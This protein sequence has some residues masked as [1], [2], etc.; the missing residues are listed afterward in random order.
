MLQL[1]HLSK[2]FLSL[3]LYLYKPISKYTTVLNADKALQTILKETK[4]LSSEKAKLRNALGRTLAEDIVAAENIPPFDNSAMDGFAVHS[5]DVKKASQ[6]IPITLSVAGE[7]SAGNVFD[8]KLNQGEAV[9]IMTGAKL[10]DGADC[11]V[12]IELVKIGDEQKVE[13][14]APS[15]AGAHIRRAGEDFKKKEVALSKGELISPAQ[16]GVLA[17]FGYSKVRVVCKPKVN[18]LAT[19][20]ELVEVADKLSEGQIRNSSSYALAGFVEQA[21]GEATLLGI[22]RDKRKR[23]RKAI[24]AGLDCDVL[25]ITGGVS[26]GKYD[27]VKDILADLG[28]GIKFWK[29]NIKPG[30]PLVFG[31]FKKTLVFGLPGNP[32]STSVTY[33]QFV[34][35]AIHKMLGRFSPGLLRLSAILD[36]PITKNDGKRHF[37][38]GIATTKGGT[39]HV[40]TT[41]T[42]SSGAMSSISKANCLI[43]IPEKI[44]SLKK[45]SKV[46]VEMLP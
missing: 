40:C 3:K 10:P 34:R 1:L 20:D 4:T 37:I 36:E 46:E 2:T 39:L 9:R 18:I 7:S 27:L 21:G 11:I 22:V 31:K 13:F 24:K 33:L 35:P 41:G 38:R 15:K 19:G 17:S 32:A 23:I 28:V 8:K 30:K 6:K 43:I 26:V 14:S 25:L 29:V 42:Q 45:G 5:A 12:P 44:S 16:L